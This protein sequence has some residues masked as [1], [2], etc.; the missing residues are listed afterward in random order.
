[1]TELVQ[2]RKHTQARAL[3]RGPEHGPINSAELANNLESTLV[4]RLDDRSV[5]ARTTK[6]RSPAV[7]SDFQ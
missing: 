6:I 1:M 5:I 3:K 4:P 2:I 7:D